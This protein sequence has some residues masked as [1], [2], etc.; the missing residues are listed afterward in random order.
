ML[1]LLYYFVFTAL[2]RLT[3]SIVA[4]PFPTSSTVILEIR[5]LLVFEIFLIASLKDWGRERR[6]AIDLLVG[7]NTLNVRFGAW[8]WYVKSG[9]LLR[10]L[11]KDNPY[12]KTCD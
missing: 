2:I 3:I 4:K 8:K 7:L 6:G 10:R 5:V 12:L 11:K 1:E 9:S